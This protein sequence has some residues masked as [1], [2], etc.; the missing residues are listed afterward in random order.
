M[1]TR[2]WVGFVLLSRCVERN[3]TCAGGSGGCLSEP[4]AGLGRSWSFSCLYP[5][6]RWVGLIILGLDGLGCSF[7]SVP[8]FF[9]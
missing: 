3:F 2:G 8:L 4:V 1:R 7:A 9:I 5:C 6:L